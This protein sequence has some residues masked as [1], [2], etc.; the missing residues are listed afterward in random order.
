MVTMFMTVYRPSRRECYFQFVFAPQNNEGRESTLVFVSLIQKTPNIPGIRRGSG[1]LEGIC[2]GVI[3]SVL[4][5]L[6]RGIE[7]FYGLLSLGH[8]R[9]VSKEVQFSLLE[10]Q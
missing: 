8:C 2:R 4:E 3:L 7:G 6:E 10:G 1:L 5:K 9:C